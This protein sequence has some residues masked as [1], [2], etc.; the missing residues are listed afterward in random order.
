MNR[1]EHPNPQFERNSYICLNGEWEFEIGKKNDAVNCSLSSKIEVPFCVESILSG[2]GI[3]DFISDCIYSK[4]IFVN[5]EDLKKRLVL[6]FGAVD[7]CAT[8]YINGQ[9]VKKHVGGYTAFEVDVTPFAKVGENRITVAVHDDVR[10][11]ILSGKQ[12]KRAHSYGC[13]YTRCTGIWQSV[14]LE[15]TPNKYIKNIKFYPCIET[16]SVKA[17]I[18]TEGCGKATVAVFLDGKKVGHAETLVEYKGNLTIPLTEKRLWELGKGGLYDVIVRFEEDEVKSYFGLR[19]V[20]YEG[21]KFLLNGKS[22]YQRM[23]LDQ[24]YYPEGVYTA[25]TLDELTQDIH[26]A[27]SLG[28]NGIRLHQ[29]VFE[30]RYL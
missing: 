14:W 27:K 28:F 3:T 20:R 4:V 15:K 24:G 5:E 9:K 8:V 7:Y 2:V 25:K 1:V 10:E 13:F 6:H 26:L 16:T 23:I 17:E 18:V 22:V 21:R 30:Q 11:C 19:E 29:K 12:S